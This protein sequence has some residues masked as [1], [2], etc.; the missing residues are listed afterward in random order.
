MTKLMTKFGTPSHPLTTSQ[1]EE[2]HA[3][4]QPS[5]QMLPLKPLKRQKG[6]WVFQAWAAHS[7]CL[8]P[9]NKCCL[10]FPSPQSRISK[11]ALLL[12]RQ[13]DPSSLQN[14][15]WAEKSPHFMLSKRKDSPS[16]ASNSLPVE[17]G[18]QTRV[19]KNNC[20]WNNISQCLGPQW[21]QSTRKEDI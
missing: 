11:L 2:I 5:S 12:S 18:I 9:C 8:V 13:A 16:E 19:R 10:C 14:K 4:L 1:S 15:P 20:K 17:P 6:V 3:P 21:F 7:P